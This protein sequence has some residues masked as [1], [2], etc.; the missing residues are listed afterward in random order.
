MNG[1]ATFKSPLRVVRLPGTPPRG[2]LKA[3]A[4]LM[5]SSAN[6]GLQALRTR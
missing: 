3:A 2:S 4:T 5:L 1:V 6:F